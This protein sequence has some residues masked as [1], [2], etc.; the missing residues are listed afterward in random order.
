M[1]HSWW[2]ANDFGWTY[3]TVHVM[4]EKHR[5]M[6]YTSMA[7]L[8]GTGLPTMSIKCPRVATEQEDGGHWLHPM[9]KTEGN[10]EPA[11]VTTAMPDLP[12][13]IWP[14]HWSPVALRSVSCLS[15]TCS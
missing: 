15:D 1:M 12:P 11:A 14:R 2:L 7:V 10:Q 9:R 8:F 13:Q 3:G 6:L 4:Y 5:L